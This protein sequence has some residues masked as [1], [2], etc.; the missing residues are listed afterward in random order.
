ME[1]HGNEGIVSSTQSQCVKQA[2]K[3]DFRGH[4]ME[5]IGKPGLKLPKNYLIPG[6]CRADGFIIHN[7]LGIKSVIEKI[8]AQGRVGRAVWPADYQRKQPP[9]QGLV[10][11]PTRTFQV[12]GR[13]PG[14]IGDFPDQARKD[15]GF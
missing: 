9:P 14:P 8:T 15:C 1:L 11:R 10:L 5:S 2:V 12:Q 13:G 3:G 7:L 6:R 4:E